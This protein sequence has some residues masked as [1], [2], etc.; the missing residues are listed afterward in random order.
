MARNFYDLP[1]FSMLTSFE[2]SARKLSIKKAASELNVTPGAVSHQ[3][4]ALETDLGRALFT[5]VHRGVELTREGKLLFETLNRDFSDISATLR[6]LRRTEDDN[7]V[8]IAVTTAVSS[9]WLTPRLAKFWKDHNAIPINQHVADKPEISGSLVDLKIRYGV[10][11]KDNSNQF[12]LFRDCLVPVC[13]E[14]FALANPVETLEDLAILPLIHQDFNENGWTTWQSWFDTLGFHGPI[15]TGMRVNN[16]IIALQAAREN[17][18][19]ML[20]WRRLIKPLLD[21][22]GL[23][24]LS[25]FELV[26]GSIF[27]VEVTNPEN[28]TGNTKTVLDWL[29]HTID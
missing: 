12:P 9:L 4:K 15:A 11:D 28:M 20:G 23:V 18:G 17:A 24:V 8:T 27:F 1:P 5:R 13:S 10:R 2:A 21:E 16:Y 14:N 26:E 7:S 25:P 6:Q 29:L 3:V 19:L 22:G